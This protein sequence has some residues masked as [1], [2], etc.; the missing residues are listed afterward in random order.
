MLIYF[1]E[2]SNKFKNWLFEEIKF[3]FYRNRKLVLE[4]L[5]YILNNQ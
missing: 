4:I 3:V 1:L 5:E 2:N